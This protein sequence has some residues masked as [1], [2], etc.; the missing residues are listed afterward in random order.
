MYKEVKEE[1]SF[2]ITNFIKDCETSR[3][4]KAQTFSNFSLWLQGKT[5]DMEEA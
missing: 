2:I 3:V 1:M 4:E 5:W